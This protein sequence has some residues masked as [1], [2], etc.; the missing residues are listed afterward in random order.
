MFFIDALKKDNIKNL[1][2]LVHASRYLLTISVS[3]LRPHERDKL[4]ANAYAYAICIKRAHLIL[5][6]RAITR[7]RTFHMQQY[8]Y[9]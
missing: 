4:H 8:V 3:L 6:A 5:R 2:F 1:I 9:M 7:A